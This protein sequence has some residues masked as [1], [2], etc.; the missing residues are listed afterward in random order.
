MHRGV[1]VLR[2][3]LTLLGRMVSHCLSGSLA[4][5]PSVQG[6]LL[7]RTGK[8]ASRVCGQPLWLHACK[9]AAED[10]VGVIYANQ[11]LARVF[12]V[13]YHKYRQ[14]HDGSKYHDV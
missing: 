14:R 7:P 3:L 1:F 13:D 5:A 11:A 12:Q 6:K 10:L 2:G 9:Q 8:A 4:S